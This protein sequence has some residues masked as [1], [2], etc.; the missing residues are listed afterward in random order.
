MVS[1]WHN[2]KDNVKKY[3]RRLYNLI[4]AAVVFL[5]LFLLTEI[6]NWQSLCLF[7]NLFE[8]KCVGC[9]MTRGFISILKL[10]FFAAANYNLLSIPLFFCMVFY[11]ALLIIDI[12][13]GREYIIKFEK[14]L[15]KKYMFPFYFVLFLAAVILKQL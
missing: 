15:S 4:G 1:L 6:N 10:D 5:I 9:G 2:I 14:M 13:L 3:C 7:Y 12:L 11:C 8:I